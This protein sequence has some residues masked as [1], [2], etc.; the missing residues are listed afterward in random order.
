MIGN[1]M[2]DQTRSIVRVGNNMQRLIALISPR[3]QDIYDNLVYLIGKDIGTQIPASMKKP[4]DPQSSDLRQSSPLILKARKITRS[5]SRQA[6]Q[7]RFLSTNDS[8]ISSSTA[9]N[10]T[11]VAMPPLS[12]PALGE[13]CNATLFVIPA[14]EDLDTKTF[15]SLIISQPNKHSLLRLVNIYKNFNETITS[16]LNQTARDQ[17]YHSL[18][19]FET[20][21][22][23][24]LTS[25]IGSQ[26][27]SLDFVQESFLNV[28]SG[29]ASQLVTDCLPLIFPICLLRQTLRVFS[30]LLG[31]PNNLQ[32][33]QTFQTYIPAVC[34]SLIRNPQCILD[35][36]P[37]EFPLSMI[38]ENMF[39]PTQ[40]PFPID[41]SF[42]EVSNQFMQLDSIINE[43]LI[44]LNIS[45][46]A[47]PQADLT[48]PSTT[49]TETRVTNSSNF[50]IPPSNNSVTARL[51]QA[52]VLGNT[53]TYPFDP[54]FKFHV[55]QVNGLQVMAIGQKSAIDVSSKELRM[56][57]E[58]PPFM[59]SHCLLPSSGLL[60]LLVLL[61]LPI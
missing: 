26:G 59:W 36:T 49:A 41:Y 5:S 24:H 15:S 10:Y 8:S 9:P 28:D 37:C 30:D 56:I 35:H 7:G 12:A 25:G 39:A 13:D 58:L 55:A 6:P 21:A 14:I 44:A 19:T 38:V 22:F 46:G 51:L 32:L 23:C 3:V 4:I 34:D 33:S 20:G 40:D 54:E 43:T 61:S 27:F 42:Q 16:F 52:V 47:V 1:L 29:D 60:S 2:D 11:T 17:C 57:N 45:E 50:S 31:I 53:L 48:D 18:F